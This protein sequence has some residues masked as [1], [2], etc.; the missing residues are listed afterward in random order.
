MQCDYTLY[1]RA[2][3]SSFFC[4]FLLH[5]FCYCCCFTLLIFFFRLLLL[6]LQSISIIS[7]RLQFKHSQNCTIHAS[8][9]F[10]HIQQQQIHK[11]CVFGKYTWLLVTTCWLAECFC[12]VSGMYRAHSLGSFANSYSTSIR[13]CFVCVDMMCL[14]GFYSSSS[15]FAN[16]WCRHTITSD[17][18]FFCCC[19]I[20]FFLSFEDAKD[21]IQCLIATEYK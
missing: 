18:S 9:S 4:L 8:I 15:S 21:T 3:S 19:F 7:I 16:M 6:R 1:L 14:N 11:R 10:A 17:A 12:R 13:V 2:F 5:L 20:S